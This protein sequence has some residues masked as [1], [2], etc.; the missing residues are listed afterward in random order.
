MTMEI[1]FLGHSGFILTGGEA[2]VAV[3]PFLEGNPVAKKKR[4][5]VRC[6]YIALT[7]GHSD[8]MG[9]AQPIAK[10][11]N[12]TVVAAWEICQFLGEK[13]VKCEP[14]NPGG[15]IQTAFGWVAFTQ[16]FHSSSFEGRYM[17]QPCGLVIHFA[18]DNFTFHH[19]G[20]T[21]L[22]SDLKLIGD[23]YNPDVSAIPVGDRFTMGPEQAR[24]A[25][26]MI[27]P[28]VAIPV[29]W[30]TFDALTSDISAFKPQG[31][32]VRVMK[33]GETWKAR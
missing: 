4:A 24:M 32:E 7:H 9:D 1:E 18:K 3:D 2:R 33:P 17:G 11:N 26:E 31:V 16:A 12:A 5:D 14:G 13:G 23:L 25:A 29:H 15:R 8:H 21:A 19:C 22:F 30:G 20:D 27:R 6:D 28:K 10:A